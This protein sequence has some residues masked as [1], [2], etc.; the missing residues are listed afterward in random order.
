MA[1]ARLWM[2][3]M[4]K[5]VKMVDTLLRSMVGTPSELVRPATENLA[6]EVRRVCW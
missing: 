1:S 2:V 4:V 6:V 5:M 3:R